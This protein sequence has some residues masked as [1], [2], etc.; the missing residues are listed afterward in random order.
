MKNTGCWTALVLIFAVFAATFMYPSIFS[1]PHSITIP[2]KAESYVW[3]N[4]CESAP[5]KL[6]DRIPAGC[7]QD[8]Y[9]IS[10]PQDYPI[11][12]VNYHFAPYY[13]VGDDIISISCHGFSNECY[14]QHILKDAFTE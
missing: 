5:Y 4:G 3:S 2:V 10:N 8:Q 11:D 13:R 14:V 12:D 9:R 7:E 6:H 1:P